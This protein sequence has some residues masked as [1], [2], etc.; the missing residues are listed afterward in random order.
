[1]IK[2]IVDTETTGLT[3][4]SSK[5]I[6]LAYLLYD[7]NKKQIVKSY[8]AFI[9]HPD[10]TYMPPAA[11]QVH[12][13]S[14]DFLNQYGKS[15]E[16]VADETY[17]DLQKAILVGHN[18]SRFDYD[19]INDLFLRT[20]YESEIINGSLIC[21]FPYDIIDTLSVAKEKLIG[22][23]RNLQACVDRLPIRPGF[24]DALYEQE[25]GDQPGNTGFH[26]ARYDVCATTMVALA[27]GVL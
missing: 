20:G 22:G 4:Y 11:E 13:I 16:E 21:I 27:L 3:H 1:M 2:A 26:D 6:Q 9:N 7:T 15:P 5:L 14:L 8:N 12:H 24:I 19:F 10:L 17:K 25:F 18:I 23:K